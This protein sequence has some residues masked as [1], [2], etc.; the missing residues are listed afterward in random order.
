MSR[1]SSTRNAPP[2]ISA[3]SYWQGNVFCEITV[4]LNTAAEGDVAYHYRC[5]YTYQIERILNSKFKNS[6]RSLNYIKK[7]AVECRKEKIA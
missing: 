6:F 1:K 3:W 7:I 5:P 2:V 4:L